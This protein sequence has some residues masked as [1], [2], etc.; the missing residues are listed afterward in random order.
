MRTTFHTP[1]FLMQAALVMSC[2]A[3]QLMP[4]LRSSILSVCNYVSSETC[5]LPLRIPFPETRVGTCKSFVTNVEDA[6]E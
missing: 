1:T 5:V 4:L 2:S 3:K 6:E